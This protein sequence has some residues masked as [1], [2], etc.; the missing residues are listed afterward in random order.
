MRHQNHL[1][2]AL[3]SSCFYCGTSQ[4]SL[5]HL[6]TS[7]QVIHLARSN[8]FTTLGLLP[9][10]SSLFPRHASPSFS[11]PL[12]FSF[13]IDAPI[14]F[15]TPILVF[16][17]AVWKFRNPALGSCSEQSNEWRAART[18]ELASTLLLKIKSRP[19]RKIKSDDSILAH[20]DLLCSTA[21]NTIVCYTDGS[22]SPNPGPSGAGASIFDPCSTL[23]DL[24]AS[25]GRGTNNYAELYAI[26]MCFSELILRLSHS[27]APAPP[28]LLFSDSLYAIQAITSTK[29]P[30][31]HSPTI[32]AL[33]ASFAALLRLTP[34]YL[35]WIRGHRDVGGNERVDK[36][37]KRFANAPAHPASSPPPFPSQK[38]SLPWPFPTSSLCNLPL[39]LLL[40]NL[41][42]PVL[43]PARGSYLTRMAVAF[44]SPPDDSGLDFKHCD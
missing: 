29:P 40:A 9:E 4:D 23:T 44:G 32:M 16:N 36:I 30:L 18:A 11:L 27:S 33:R 26:G 28:I 38:S 3:V 8:F 15:S 42:S 31:V 19:T 2:L 43:A 14:S 6:L 34:S 1:A 5:V 41:P 17:L 21:S 37:A 7:C 25:L 35:H 20:N 22:A 10:F 12:S 39:H 13:L 24:G